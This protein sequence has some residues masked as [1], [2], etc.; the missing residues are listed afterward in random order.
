MQEF[1]NDV[2][3]LIELDLSLIRAARA[4]TCRYIR[5]H[6]SDKVDTDMTLQDLCIAYTE[7]D[8]GVR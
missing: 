2:V 1:E 7:S 5:E 6:A 3:S 4:M 8:E